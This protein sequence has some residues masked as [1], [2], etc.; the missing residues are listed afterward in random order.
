MDADRMQHAKAGK[1]S[2]PGWRS[3]A[4]IYFWVHAVLAEMFAE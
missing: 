1:C 4:M 2:S 3:R